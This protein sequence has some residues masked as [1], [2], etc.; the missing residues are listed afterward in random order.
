[1]IKE[2]ET[3]KNP[4][5]ERVMLYSQFPGDSTEYPAEPLRGRIRTGHKAEVRGTEEKNR[6]HGFYGKKR[7]RHG[8]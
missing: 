1:M 5:P 8:K 4:Q 3:V 7:L 6:Y 2:R